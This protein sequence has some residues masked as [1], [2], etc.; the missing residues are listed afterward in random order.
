[1]SLAL[2]RPRPGALLTAA[3]AVVALAPAAASAAPALPVTGQQTAVAPDPG[4]VSALTGLGATVAGT[5]ATTVD[6]QGRFVYPIT[7][8]SLTADLKGTVNHTGGLQI[9]TR[10]GIKFGIQQFVIDTRK[11]PVLTAVPTL[12]GYGLGI[13]VPVASITDLAVTTDG[14][15]TVVSGTLKLTDIGALYINTFLGTKAVSKGTVFG[16]AEARVTLGAPPAA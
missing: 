15:A 13:R 5:G 6:G 7:G 9:R 16:A 2:R 4:L 14:P 10:A 3:L 1:M 11:S 8:G 12:G